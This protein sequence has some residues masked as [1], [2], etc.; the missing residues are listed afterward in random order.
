VCVNPDRAN[1]MND[2]S[3][4]NKILEAGRKGWLRFL[5]QISLWDEWIC[6][7]G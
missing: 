3:T 7:G 6:R 5:E 4:M 1:D 2:K